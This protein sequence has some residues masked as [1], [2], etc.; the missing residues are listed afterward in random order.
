MLSSFFVCYQFFILNMENWMR[1]WR[2]DV[3]LSR[4]CHSVLN[5]YQEK[6][7]D[8]FGQVINDFFHT[9]HLNKRE[10]WNWELSRLGLSD[11]QRFH[12]GVQKIEYFFVVNFK[13]ADGN[14]T[15]LFGHLFIKYSLEGPGQNS[16]LIG[17]QRNLIILAVRINLWTVSYNCI[18]FSRAC[19]TAS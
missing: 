7:L 1:S 5:Y 2:F 18:G 17:Q 9:D 16:S 12:G 13:K 11:F 8:S 15:V 14:A 10:P 6:Y 19:L 4:A 3:G